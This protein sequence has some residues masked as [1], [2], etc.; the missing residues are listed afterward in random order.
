MAIGQPEKYKTNTQT[1]L[2][3]GMA[4]PM[5]EYAVHADYAHIRKH[6]AADAGENLIHIIQL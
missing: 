1:E 5:R 2:P 4:M 6:A 3:V